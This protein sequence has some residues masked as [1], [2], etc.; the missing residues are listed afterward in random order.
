MQ[1]VRPS[2]FT[3]VSEEVDFPLELRV[4]HDEAVTGKLIRQCPITPQSC[5]ERKVK[6]RTRNVG[7]TWHR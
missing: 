6:P 7:Y 2:S 5:L 1:E 3:D 4:W